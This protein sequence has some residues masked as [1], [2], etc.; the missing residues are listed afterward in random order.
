[1][2]PTVKIPNVLG[3]I[4]DNELPEAIDNFHKSTSQTLTGLRSYP[5]KDELQAAAT[6]WK[7]REYYE[8]A[9]R[10]DIRDTPITLND[11]ERKAIVREADHAFSERGMSIVVA[12]VSL[13]AYL[14]GFAQ[15]SQNGANLFAEL[16]IDRRADTNSTYFGL[17]NATVYLSAAILGCPLAAPINSYFG[18][19][20]AIFVASMFIFISSI[21]S[22]AIPL[23]TPG[24]TD[25]PRGWV[26]LSGIRIIGGVGMGLKA[27]STPI[28]AAEMAVGYWRGSFI[29]MWQLWVAFGIMMSFIVNIGLNSI[30]G[31]D[32]REL[33]L[34]LIMGSPAVFALVLMLAVFK[35]PESFRY[36]MTP[37]IEQE[38]D[39]EGRA[40]G[41]V[42]SNPNTNPS[43]D[44]CEAT[45]SGSDSPGSGGPNP[46]ESNGQE[47]VTARMSSERSHN[48]L[49]LV[50]VSPFQ[51]FGR[52]AWRYVVKYW[53]ILQIRRLRNAAIAAG[54]VAFTQQLSGINVMAF[55]GGSML[56]KAQDGNTLTDGEIHHAM[57]INV[58]FGML[59]FLFC[60]PAI[61]YIDSLGRR[62]ILLFTIPWMAVGMLAAA[63]SYGRVDIKVVAWWLYFHAIWYSPGMGP[64]P[65]VLAAES[66]PLAFRETGASMAISV[67]FLF[68]GVLAWL[69]PCLDRGIEVSGTLGVFAGLNLAA[70]IL[71][72]LLVEETGGVRL[73]ALGIVFKE[74]K[75]DF[76][77]FQVFEFMPWLGNFLIGRSRWEDRPARMINYEKRRVEVVPGADDRGPGGGVDG[78][79]VNRVSFNRQ[80]SEGPSS[81]D[82]D[83]R[84]AAKQTEDNL[85]LAP[86]NF[87]NEELSPKI[88]DIVTPMGKPCR[89]DATT[90]VR[91]ELEMLSRLWPSVVLRHLSPDYIIS[92]PWY[93]E[94]DD[95]Y[96]DKQSGG[97]IILLESPTPTGAWPG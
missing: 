23:G 28:L 62:K 33:K 21:A 18:R 89:A 19:R 75:R 36:Y 87:W 34:R 4:S 65:F 48:I 58:V 90:I 93:A 86:S 35:C 7:N 3:R 60:L 68:A 77:R 46:G 1:M 61:R 12:T 40:I 11:A 20:G 76:M 50:I 5:S 55:Y 10:A 31:D 9:A 73:E 56:I 52:S 80:S 70:F 63:V 27:V 30:Q 85:V 45:Q 14:Q 8:N 39:M 2:A 82:D 59:N 26:L 54:V 15:S 38:S 53:R 81:D 32:R 95:R 94:G 74:P 78:G 47:N 22:S 16:W 13:S 92:Q 97:F 67:N 29:L 79:V 24:S 6:I 17:A 41:L 84:V 69:L 91:I 96:G 72:F 37:G 66:F 43:P 71:V 44:E 88:E 25:P 49:Q 51:G 42:P 64:V 57:V 83:M